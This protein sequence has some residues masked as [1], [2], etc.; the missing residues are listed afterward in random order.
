MEPPPEPGRGT[1]ARIV[2]PVGAQ[3]MQGH[4]A[5]IVTR[6]LAGAVDF[7]VAVLGVGLGYLT[8]LAIRYVMSPRTFRLLEPGFGLLLICL[9]W[10]LT[11]YLTLAW[12]TT[13]RSYGARLLGLRVVDAHGRRL[14][15]SVALLRALLCVFVPIVV[16][17][18]VVSRENR[19]AADVLLRTSVIY[20]WAATAH[21][22]QGNPAG[23]PGSGTSGGTVGS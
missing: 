11:A 6:L 12:G 8:V 5:G 21:T 16:F 15:P 23:G 18:V 20:D 3:S 22:P 9:L 1:L 7:V 14:R 13:G 17:W 19:S 4:R 2:V 10:L